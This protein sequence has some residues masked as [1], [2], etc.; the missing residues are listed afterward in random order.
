[1]AALLEAGGSEAPRTLASPS[2]ANTSPLGAELVPHSRL[3]R[4]RATTRVAASAE[5]L[6]VPGTLARAGQK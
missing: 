2:T 1:M 4:N 5:R 3:R 6:Q